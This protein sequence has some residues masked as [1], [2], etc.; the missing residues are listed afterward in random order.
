MT[1][2]RSTAAAV[3]VLVL[4]TVV[5]TVALLDVNRD[6]YQD[7]VNFDP[8]GNDQQWEA[9]RT[10]A[11]LMYTS[12]HSVGHLCATLLGVLIGQITG[13]TGRLRHAGIAAAGGAGLA[14]VSLALALP[15]ASTGIG[16]L[17]MVDE[18]TRHGFPFDHNLL[19][20]Q[21]VFAFFA[22]GFVAFPLFAVLGLGAS[23][24]RGPRLAAV[25]ALAWHPVSVVG[26]FL[27]TG[28]PA[29]MWPLYSNAGTARLVL[30]WPVSALVVALVLAVWA[31]GACLIGF[32]SR[33][34]PVRAAPAAETGH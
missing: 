6:T 3:A 15:R 31:A 19:H 29:V 25:L 27:T 18:L 17:W 34:R 1:T 13:R 16:R 14:A 10:S 11:A 33:A 12:G 30:R 28:V 26:G 7:W 23:L 5:A 2:R 32:A 22:L 24:A 8:Q 9:L 21:G 20:D 4:A